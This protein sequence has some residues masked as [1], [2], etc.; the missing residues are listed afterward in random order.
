M[1]FMSIKSSALPMLLVTVM[2]VGDSCLG[3]WSCVMMLRVGSL[4]QLL[5]MGSLLLL[6]HVA[7]AH[8][9]VL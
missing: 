8:L 3:S 2:M 7:Y 6:G 4:G 9:G 5:N 1:P